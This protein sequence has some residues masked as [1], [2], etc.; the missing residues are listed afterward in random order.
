MHLTINLATKFYYNQPLLK[1]VLGAF[2]VLL[3]IVLIWGIR[4]LQAGHSELLKTQREIELMNKTLTPHPAGVSEKEYKHHCSQVASLNKVL[5]Q[6]SKSKLLLLDTLETVTP[7]GISYSQIT[8][9]SNDNVVKL[10]GRAL[11]FGILSE[12][13]ERLEV[14]KNINNPTLISTED[15][16]KKDIP[17][18]SAGMRFALTFIWN[19]A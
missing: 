17:G 6:R 2:S 11:S 18:H 12:L 14:A 3:M 1:R 13:L 15:V 8:P 5:A 9:E 16:S 4:H 7:A 10:E 19:G